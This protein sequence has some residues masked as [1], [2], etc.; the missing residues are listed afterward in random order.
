MVHK[1]STIFYL[2]GVLLSSI[3]DLRRTGL[4]KWHILQPVS[5]SPLNAKLP[6]VVQLFSYKKIGYP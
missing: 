5:R 3:W 6:F 2:F 4:A 1:V